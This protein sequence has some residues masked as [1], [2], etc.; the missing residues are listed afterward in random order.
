MTGEAFSIVTAVMGVMATLFVIL[1]GLAILTV[2]VLF[3]VDVTQT[4]SAI[5]RNY[6]VVGRFRFFFEHPGEF[7]RQYFFA[8]DREEMPF[9]RAQR[10]WAYRAARNHAKNM[11]YE[12]GLIAHSCG[13]REPRELRRFHARIVSSNGLSIPLNEHHP[14]MLP[15]IARTTSA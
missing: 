15:P 1:A 10:S 13:V 4:K 2:I 6:T 7:F 12:V 14:D 8:L 3:V 9:N 11:L 5:R